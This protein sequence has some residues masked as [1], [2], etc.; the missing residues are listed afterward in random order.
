MISAENFFFCCENSGVK[1]GKNPT[2]GPR[3]T[4][5]TPSSG[6]AKQKRILQESHFPFFRSSEACD[7]CAKLAVAPRGRTYS[8]FRPTTFDRAHHHHVRKFYRVRD[9]LDHHRGGAK[10]AFSTRCDGGVQHRPSRLPAPRAG[11][12]SGVTVGLASRRPKSAP[13]TPSSRIH[14]A[15][16]GALVRSLGRRARS[17]SQ[18]S[19]DSTSRARQADTPRGRE[20]G[21]ERLTDPALPP[22]IGGEVGCAGVRRRQSSGEQPE[23]E[24]GLTVLTA[25]THV[26]RKR[27]PRVWVDE[28]GACR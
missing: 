9:A 10:S 11:V 1:R 25:S 16:R 15:A 12:A 27:T 17:L 24:A 26:R 20:D 21:G 4:L 14:L 7:F 23:A 13:R 19:S 28:C 2:G 18:H 22:A 3:P 6:P 8:R 5:P